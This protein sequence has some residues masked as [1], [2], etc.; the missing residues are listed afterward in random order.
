[1]NPFSSLGFSTHSRV[2]IFGNSLFE[3]Y[4]PQLLRQM[5]TQQQ[6][7]ELKQQK[8]LFK[9]LFSRFYQLNQREKIIAP[10]D[11]VIIGFSGG[12]DSLL[13]LNILATLRRSN[14][15]PV[16]LIAIHV[17]ND[18]VGYKLDIEHSR[19]IC[20]QLGVT[21]ITLASEEM[22]DIEDLDTESTTFCVNCGRNRRRVLLKYAKE[23]G[24]TSIA[25]GHHMD[26][27]A[28]TLL[29]NQM[30]C[31]CI[32]GIPAQFTTEK[33]GIKFIRPLLDIPVKLIQEWSS[34]VEM[35]R[36]VRCNYEKDSMRGE[37]REILAQ[38]KKKHPHIVECI[39]QAPHNIKSEY[40]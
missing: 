12:K 21:F 30:F 3:L 28:E 22:P 39:V 4:K 11:K 35:P 15:F 27:V 32:A 37:V 2:T 6:K 18:Q 17:T 5:S 7:K 10:N 24:Y 33:Y 8:A 19:S 14:L 26:D 13:V 34:H 25:L 38:L 20:D 23:H 1:M 9:K 36:L 31:S 40:L 29:M 16:E